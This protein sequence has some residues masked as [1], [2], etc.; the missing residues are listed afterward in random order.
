MSEKPKRKVWQ[1]HLS[2]AVILMFAAGILMAVNYHACTIPTED[3]RIYFV[4]HG[5]PLVAY[6]DLHL[7]ELLD[8]SQDVVGGRSPRQA[9]AIPFSKI[10]RIDIGWNR[11]GIVTNL[12]VAIVILITGVFASEWLIR[13]REARKR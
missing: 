11:R 12:F 4:A 8:M 13:R 10:C 2:T 7:H 1:F 3:N 5:W 9:E 6:Q